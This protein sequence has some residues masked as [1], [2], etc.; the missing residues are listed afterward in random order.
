M[1][2]CTICERVPIKVSREV[3]TNYAFI[4][5]SILARGIEPVLVM[6][7]ENTYINV[8][9]HM[10]IATFNSSR[11]VRP[12]SLKTTFIYSKYPN[13]HG[14]QD[15]AN[16]PRLLN[17]MFTIISKIS[18]VNIIRRFHGSSMS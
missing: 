10:H 1:L 14:N 9:N 13:I 7:I 15:T 6:N 8:V 18:S 2:P 5:G 4:T 3:P 16:L 17:L 11:N 12:F